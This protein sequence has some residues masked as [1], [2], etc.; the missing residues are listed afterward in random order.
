MATSIS[1]A[2]S[3][4]T[5]SF[6]LSF[7]Q[8]SG[9]NLLPILN[10]FAAISDLV[11]NSKK[12]F[13]LNISLSHWELQFPFTWAS[14]TI[15]YLAINL[16]ADSTQLFSTNSLAILRQV[17]SLMTQWSSLPLSWIGRINVIKMAILPQLL[18]LFFI[19]G[20]TDSC[21]CQLSTHSAKSGSS[22]RLGLTEAQST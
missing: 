14:K 4:M 13:A 8:V 19:Q 1:F 6:F 20:P 16:A 15:P 11:V 10:A 12:S 9:P 17:S 18:F 22:V 5:F 7:P 2:Y 3:Q 21:P